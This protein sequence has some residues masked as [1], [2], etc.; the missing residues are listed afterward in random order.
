[1]RDPKC[2][3]REELFSYLHVLGSEAKKAAPALRK[4]LKE[5]DRFLRAGAAS[6]LLAIDRDRSRND[7]LKVL[8]EIVV[9]EKLDDPTDRLVCRGFRAVGRDS[10]AAVPILHRAI[11]REI[12]A[13]PAE[14]AVGRLGAIGPEA[15]ETV[16]MLKR[17][18]ESDAKEGYRVDAAVALWRVTGEAEDSVKAISGIW[19]SAKEWLPRWWAINALGEMGPSARSALP[20]LRTA[21]RSRE[22]YLAAKAALA[23]WQVARR[24]K[25]GGVVVDPRQEAIDVLIALLKKD[26]ESRM[27]AAAAL[28]A[29]GREAKRAIPALVAALEDKD[30]DAR[31]FILQA[32]DAVGPDATACKAI[33][34]ALADPRRDVRIEAAM[35]LTKTN[36]ISKAVVAEL[37][38]YYQR[39]PLPEVAEALG[40]CGAEAKEVVPLLVETGRHG[41]HAVHVAA[42]RALEKI[43]ADAAARVRVR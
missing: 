23:F 10:Q 17:I 6:T 14:W 15:R 29:I 36:R 27:D 19:A 28:C 37:A 35:A 24:E 1:L 21:F 39:D 33:E 32:L 22:D 13:L 4:M 43:D 38:R 18:A 8:S 9:D 11:R 41:D 20:L 2:E 5:E 7:A 25:Y 26:T 16:P 42:V 3:I 31:S 34:K 12:K 40:R 30:P